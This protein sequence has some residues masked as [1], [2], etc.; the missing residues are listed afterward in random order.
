MIP[1]SRGS[2][3]VN[4][5]M[6]CCRRPG[7]R[8]SIRVAQTIRI[9]LQ[10]GRPGFDHWV[11]KITQRR[12]TLPTPVFWPREFH[13]LY[14]PW[15]RKESET[16]ERLSLSTHHRLLCSIFAYLSSLFSVFLVPTTISS[17]MKLPKGN[18]FCLFTLNMTLFPFSH[19]VLDRQ[20]GSLSVFWG[21]CDEFF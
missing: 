4:N 2:E 17:R 9:C 16:T 12:E 3:T 14:N 7:K 1:R 13:G 18:N 8:V 5:C 11:G 10:C 15:G 19:R 6:P 20:L 21:E